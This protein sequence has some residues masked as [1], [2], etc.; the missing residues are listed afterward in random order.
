M[1][2]SEESHVLCDPVLFEDLRRR[3]SL[4]EVPEC[5]AAKLR[6]KRGLPCFEFAL[7]G[8]LDL[9]H[10]HEMLVDRRVQ[11]VLGDVG[12]LGKTRSFSGA[13]G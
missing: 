5:D 7:P 3:D 13:I 6:Q 8:R 2:G 4:G 1:P 10:R 12:V 9:G 11:L